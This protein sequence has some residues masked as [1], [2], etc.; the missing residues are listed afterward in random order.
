M[1]GKRSP[2]WTWHWAVLLGVYLLCLCPATVFVLKE[3]NTAAFLWASGSLILWCVLG[4]Y[5][6][7]GFPF[8]FDTLAL[9]V[10][11][12]SIV[13]ILCVLARWLRALLPEAG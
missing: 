10:C 3:L 4:S 11:L 13:V 8:L 2:P 7:T 12:G 6:G 5:N 9:H 1:N